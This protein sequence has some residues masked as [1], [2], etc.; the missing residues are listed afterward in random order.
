MGSE[1]PI[2][3]FCPLSLIPAVGWLSGQT[4]EFLV[5][6]RETYRVM[7]ILDSITTLLAAEEDCR[8]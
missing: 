8:W 2:W 3:I 7:E 6:E 1:L 5:K 4:S